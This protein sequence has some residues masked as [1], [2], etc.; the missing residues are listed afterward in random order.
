MMCVTSKLFSWNTICSF[1][2]VSEFLLIEKKQRASR[3]ESL[4][5]CNVSLALSFFFCFFLFLCLSNRIVL[6]YKGPL[7][8]ENLSYRAFLVFSYWLGT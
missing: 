3:G 2:R 1:L 4:S 6:N 7:Y 8:S 5:D